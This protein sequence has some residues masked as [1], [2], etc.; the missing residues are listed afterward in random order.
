MNANMQYATVIDDDFQMVH[1]KAKRRRLFSRITGKSTRMPTIDDATAGRV[2]TNECYLGACTIEVDQIVGSESRADDFTADFLP[3]KTHTAHRWSRID[4]AH[5][6]GTELPAIQ[7]L[8]VDGAYF[9]RD[10]NHRVSVAKAKRKA[11]ID[12]EVTRIQTKAAE[13]VLTPTNPTSRTGALQPS[14]A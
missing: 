7:V 10:G 11:F 6:T 2:V 4:L 13:S 1:F 14:V 5:L 8:E 3:L 9:V 12:A